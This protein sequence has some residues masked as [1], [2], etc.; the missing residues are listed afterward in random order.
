VV[1]FHLDAV[2]RALG[3][4]FSDPG[5]LLLSLTHRSHTS[6][7]ED[8]VSNERLEFLGDAV[9][10][11]VIADELFQRFDLSEGAMAKTRAEVV[12]TGSLA[13]IAGSLGIGDHLLM[14]SGEDESGGRR[15][16]SILADSMEA[17]LG[18]VYLDG[19]MEA[20]RALI[21]QL[22]G[23]R[24][25]ERAAAPG[26]GDSKTRLQ[27]ILAIDGRLAEY[28][29]EGFGPDHERRFS[30]TVSTGGAVLGSGQ[31]T[32][33]KRAEQAAARAAIDALDSGADA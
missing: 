2:E 8:G 33:K 17:V 5:L 10:G 9:L 11:L 7:V 30:A 29:V 28:E 22:W 21:L 25:L 4:E 32:S 19:G 20:V 14:S 1:D 6:D 12:D 13:V 27:E 16:D 23:D 18:A 26:V 24:I 31:G 3:Y 15:K